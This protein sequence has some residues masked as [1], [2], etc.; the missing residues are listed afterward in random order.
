VVC[1]LAIGPKVRG[2]KRCQVQWFFKGDAT[3]SAP[4]FGG[5]VKMSAPYRKILR[6]VKEPLEV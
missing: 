3:R 5:E 4:S 1:V 2:F 6:H